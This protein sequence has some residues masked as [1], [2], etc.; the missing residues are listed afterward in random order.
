MTRQT[1]D[2]VAEK[3]FPPID[4]PTCYKQFYGHNR[5]MQSSFARMDVRAFMGRMSTLQEL[6]ERRERAYSLSLL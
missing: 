5:Q 6:A 2:E 3:D 1:G 4:L